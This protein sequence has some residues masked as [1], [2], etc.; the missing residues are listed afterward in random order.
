MSANPTH[1][2]TDP[3]DA[4]PLSAPDSLLP[5]L[6]A[7]EPVALISPTAESSVVE[8]SVVESS[9]TEDGVAE[10][11]LDESAADAAQTALDAP[12]SSLPG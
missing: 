3:P 6:S 4:I 2:Q 9:V 5:L 10:N 7:T 12:A 11:T 1:K 8:S